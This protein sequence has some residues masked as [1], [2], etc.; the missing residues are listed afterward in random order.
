MNVLPV[1]TI[2]PGRILPIAIAT[3]LGARLLAFSAED[4]TR[5]AETRAS[6]AVEDRASSPAETG[7][8]VPAG[9]PAPPP[10]PSRVLATET[11]TAP[12]P[13][14]E[15]QATKGASDSDPTQSVIFSPRL[16]YYNLK[17][18]N[19]T[20]ALLLRADRPFRFGKSAG[21]GPK[22]LIFRDDIPIVSAH[23]G[24]DTDSGLGDIYLQALYIPYLSPKFA[25]ATGSGLFTPTA[26]VD[27]LGRGK[28]ILAPVVAPVW[29]LPHRRG[30]F[31]FKVQDN[32][33]FAGDEDRADLH[34]TQFQPTVVWRFAHRWWAYGDT[35]AIVDWE[36][37]GH[38]HFKSGVQLGRMFKSKVGGWIQLDVPWGGFQDSSYKLKVAALWVR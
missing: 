24:D 34:Y 13:A 31:Y 20:T 5:P 30:L 1:T 6:A 11:Q 8:S 37:N 3:L 12:S 27:T 4:P 2:R 17:D 22:M 35:E 18:G 29:F 36:S 16:E 38:D 21:G 25:F 23:V 14:P 15:A 28:W 9:D 26:T 10:E 19:W 7:A 32:I 33:S